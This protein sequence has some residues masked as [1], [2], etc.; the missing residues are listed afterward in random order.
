MKCPYCG[1]GIE[2][3]IEHIDLSFKRRS[4]LDYVMKGGAAGVPIK[5]LKNKFFPKQS[6]ITLRT[7]MH[8][9]NQKIVPNQ[10]IRKGG[11]IKVIR[12]N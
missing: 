12:R 6:D 11:V 2:R 1:N 4:I 8:G 5:E 9:I 3:K 10:M 7:T